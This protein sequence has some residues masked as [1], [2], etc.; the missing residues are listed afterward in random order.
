MSPD[1]D[2][3]VRDAVEA[4]LGRV[5]ELWAEMVDYHCNLDSCFWR[6]KADGAEIFQKWMAEAL[7]DDK[8]V[9]IVAEMDGRVV[10]FVHGHLTNAPPPMVDKISGTITD[11]AVTAGH[12]DCGIGKQMMAVVLDWFR[13]CSAEEVTLMAALP[14]PDAIRFYEF[15]G[16]ER[17]LVSMRKSL[18]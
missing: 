7:E 17:H 18:R 14:N 3:I 15:L 9:L 5:G 11:V 16:F 13:A 4:D 1:A 2:V 10:G 6:R 8:R 12:R